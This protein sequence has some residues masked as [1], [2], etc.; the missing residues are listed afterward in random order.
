MGQVPSSMSSHS[1]ALAALDRQTS[2]VS[3]RSPELP[4]QT[5]DPWLV[6]PQV[7][8]PPTLTEA[9]DPSWGKAWPYRFSPSR[10][11]GRR[12]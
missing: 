11:A 12:P 5:R 10:P 6:T 8:K 4:Q 1:A 9:K 3:K 7:C 2:N